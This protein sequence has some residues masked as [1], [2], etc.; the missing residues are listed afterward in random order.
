MAV[1]HRGVDRTRA[2]M[3]DGRDRLVRE[4]GQ[5]PARVS[6]VAM[7]WDL[8]ER[9]P[10]DEGCARY[11]AHLLGAGNYDHNKTLNEIQFVL[12]YVAK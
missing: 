1:A 6:L 9:A 10:E 8:K 11:I 4:R 12:C 2:R 5:W 3:Q 7:G